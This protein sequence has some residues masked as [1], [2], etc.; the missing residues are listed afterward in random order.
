VVANLGGR[1]RETWLTITVSS[2]EKE[3]T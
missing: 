1:Q 3:T 2:I